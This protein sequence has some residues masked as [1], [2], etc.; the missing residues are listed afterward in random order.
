LIAGNKAL[1]NTDDFPVVNGLRLEFNDGIS[2]GKFVS[3]I[4]AWEH[5]E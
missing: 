1:I 2:D 5:P 4:S 3:E